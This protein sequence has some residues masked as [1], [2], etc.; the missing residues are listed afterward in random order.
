MTTLDPTTMRLAALAESSNDAI[1]SQG[2]DGT[3]ET[4]NRAAERLFGFAAA[5][6][7][8]RPF[9]SIVNVDATADEERAL[10]AALTG[11]IP[12]PFETI[13]HRPDHTDLPISMALSPVLTPDG[14]VVGLARIARDISRQRELEREALRLAAIVDS[15][16]DAIVSKDLNGIVQTWNG[17]AERMFGYT[18]EDIVGRS[19]TLIIP[20]DRLS[21]EHDVLRRIRAG[22][23]VDHFETIRRRKDGTPI[24]ISL[25][26]SPIKN[27]EGAIIG[28]SKIARDITQQQQM[29][30]DLAHANRAKDEFL[31]TLSHELRTP[32]NAVLGYTRMLRMQQ[33]SEDQRDRFIEVIERNA[34]LLA[35]LVSDVLDVSSIVTGKTRINPVVCNLADILAAAAENVRPAADAKGV[36]LEMPPP[37]L[38]PIL[39]R[40]DSDRMQQVFWNL[41]SNAVKF[42]PRGGRIA[43]GIAVDGQHVLVSITDTGIGL[44]PDTLQRIFDR[45]WQVDGGSTRQSGGLGLGLSL[46]RHFVELHG[47]TIS[48]TSEGLGRGA[49]FIVTLPAA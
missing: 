49:T 5:A 23:T 21:E 30:R 4:W 22:L 32:L 7:I 19:I 10:T 40:C 31:A 33:G 34:R 35:Q 25:S 3:I 47:G 6:A 41:F 36:T 14:D 15:S 42:T 12:G 28:A 8:G 37:A 17:A 27:A 38:Q 26:V 9:A 13:V 43:G 16:E 45:F 2:L 20:A 44:A 1:I 39:S 29:A 24:E 48:A 11:H 46:A 18:A